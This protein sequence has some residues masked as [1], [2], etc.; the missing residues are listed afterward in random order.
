MSLIG[1]MR[2][3]YAMIDLLHR[4]SH[5]TEKSV[6]AALS[7][8][9]SLDLNFVKRSMDNPK[10]DGFAWDFYQL[11]RNPVVTTDFIEQT[12]GKPGYEW[13][14]VVLS[15]NPSMT[16]EFIERTLGLPEYDWCF[17]YLSENTS[18]T[19]E[20]VERTLGKP[21]YKWDLAGLSVNQSITPDFVERTMNKPKYDGS[22]WD[23]KALSENPLMTLEFIEKTMNLVGVNWDWGTLAANPSNRQP[24]DLDALAKE[25]SKKEISSSITIKGYPW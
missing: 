14:I 1:D 16:P 2:T 22:T 4:S 25:L 6:M 20:F 11:G 7:R 12:M 9:R 24:N 23:F 17:L 19:P 3:F 5:L 15:I 21:G 13:N 10:Y 18:M 8:N